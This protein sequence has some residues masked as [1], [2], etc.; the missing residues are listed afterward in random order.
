MWQAERA[1]VHLSF[2]WEPGL[3]YVSLGM[4]EWRLLHRDRRRKSHSCNS[5]EHCQDQGTWGLPQRCRWESGPGQLLRFWLLGKE[6]ND[7][8]VIN[9]H[10][11]L[12]F[13]YS[14]FGSGEIRKFSTAV[15]YKRSWRR[16]Q[17]VYS[18]AWQGDSL[19]ASLQVAFMGLSHRNSSRV[20]SISRLR[21][22]P[23]ASRSFL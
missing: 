14:C 21:I 16:Q 8:L 5:P 10:I 15:S 18:E 2:S 9:H 6:M 1:S 22:S 11:C 17:I 4:E 13:I 19:E 12:T 3:T 20:F 7:C 23:S